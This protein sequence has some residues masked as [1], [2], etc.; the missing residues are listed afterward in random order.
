MLAAAAVLFAA[1]IL[2]DGSLFDALK[3]FGITDPG[4]ES[5]VAEAR[6]DA[7]A[8]ERTKPAIVALV[9]PGV[10]VRSVVGRREVAAVA[11]ALAKD[12]AV[13]RASS[14]ID[15]GDRAMVSRDGRAAY[16]LGFLIESLDPLYADDVVDRLEAEV[17]RRAGVTLGGPAVAN[18]QVDGTVEE[19]LRRAELIAF[20]LLL[21]LSFFVFRSLIAALLV[22]LVGAVASIVTLGALRLLAEV[23]DISVFAVNIVTGLG[24]GLAIDYSLFIVSRYREELARSGPGAEALRQTLRSAGRTVAFSAITVAA[25]LAALLVFPQRFLYSMGLGG[26]IVAL[27]SGLVALTVLPAA[28][29]LLG[30]RINALAPGRLRR[31][32]EAEASGR[33]GGWY[34]FSRAVMRRPGAVAIVTATA[35]I[36]VGSPFLRAEFVPGEDP[37]ILPERFGAKQVDSALR[38]RFE[39]YRTSPVIVQVEAPAAAGVRRDLHSYAGELASLAHVALVSE[40][41]PAGPGL[42]R[43]EAWQN[44]DPNSD[45]GQEVVAEIR[46]LDA[47]FT[48]RVAG[49]SAEF[50]DQKQSMV[51]HLL[52]FAAIIAAATFVLLFL[53]TGSVVLP[54]K[55]LLMNLLTVAAAF[56]ILV[57]VFQDG[58]LEGL[59]GYTSEGGLNSS[60]PLLLFAVIFGLS[61]DYGVFLLTRIKEARDAGAGETD[62]VAIGLERTGRVVTYAALLLCIAIGSFA[63]SQIVFIKEVGVGIA[64]GVLIDATIVRA[65]LVPSL[66]GLL[67]RWN[68]WAPGPLR[69]MH[70]R[71]GLSEG[72]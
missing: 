72:P 24:L 65:L 25:T 9:E 10:A 32:S 48:T 71:L 22:P 12:P 55:A 15:S 26:A 20:P 44:V 60:Q 33:H 6:F 58:R 43:L 27:L 19:D 47:P 46:A 42:W 3:P 39:A 5:S 21:L 50:V 35:L 16:V 31:A 56:G 2:A 45:A 51:E 69:Q 70:A 49:A 36:A 1:G 13:A 30:E 68:W 11:T 64:V 57:V 29:A 40:P 17:G 4:S 23:T 67:G 38:D 7:A 52:P 18:R 61:T 53:M 63:T 8:G 62:S 41:R 59:L 54:V 14:F 28:L 34:R 37:Q 66:M